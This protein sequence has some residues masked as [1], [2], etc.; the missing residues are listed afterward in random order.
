MPPPSRAPSRADHPL[1]LHSFL[2]PP[3]L[4][5]VSFLHLHYRTPSSTVTPCLF[6]LPSL[7]HSLFHRHFLPP[8][9]P[10]LSISHLH[11]HCLSPSSTVTSCLTPPLHALSPPAQ[12]YHHSGKQS[13]NNLLKYGHCPNFSVSPPNPMYVRHLWSSFFA[14][15]N[16]RDNT[17]SLNTFFRP[18]LVI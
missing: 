16:T 2:F 3:P 4:L 18:I 7:F 14:L 13:G 6:S 17:N 5:L 1:H 10:S 12:K 8:P 15:P 9:P 11:R